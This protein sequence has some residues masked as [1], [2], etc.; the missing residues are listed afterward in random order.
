[1]IE[2]PAPAGTLRGYLSRPSSGSPWPGVL[3]LHELLGLNDDIRAITDR[4]ASEGYL[5][6]APDLFSWGFTP[7]C[8]VQTVAGLI[9]GRRGRVFEDI[10]ASRSFL[11]D[12]TD[13]TGRAGVIG[14]CMGGQLALLVSPGPGFAV[15]APN[16]GPVPEDAEQALRGACP[17]V[18]SFGGRDRLLRGHGDRLESA[19]EHLGI[20]HDVKTYPRAGH[21]FLSEYR[22]PLRPAAAALGFTH[23]EDAAEDAWQRILAFFDEHLRRRGP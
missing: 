12:R 19:L 15:A 10:E 17:L 3:V 22:G 16:Y 8:L 20:D 5:A 6:V 9:R 14:F 4:L 21:S 23:D 11:V 13:C 2:I 18:A 7:R 1:M